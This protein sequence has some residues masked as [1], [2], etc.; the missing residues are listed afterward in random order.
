[1]GT[2]GLLSTH[3]RNAMDGISVLTQEMK[4]DRFVANLIGELFEAIT[5]GER[6]RLLSAL[7]LPRSRLVLAGAVSAGVAG[8]VTRSSA[9][10]DD[11]GIVGVE[12]TVLIEPADVIRLAES[13]LQAGDGVLENVVQAMLGSPVALGTA[14]LAMLVAICM[15]RSR[16][17]REPL[18]LVGRGAND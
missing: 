12:T 5:P 10:S 1:M 8:N 2:K 4:S 18:R 3:C 6:F 17:R 7:K 13:A 9:R 15:R 14:S 11:G 16:S